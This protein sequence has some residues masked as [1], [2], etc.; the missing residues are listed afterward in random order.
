MNRHFH[1]LVPFEPSNFV[2][3][4][5]VTSLCEM[6]GFTL[7]EA[8]DAVLLSRPIYQAFKGDFGTKAK[9]A[10]ILKKLDFSPGSARLMKGRVECEFVSF[11]DRDQFGVD[12][13]GQ[14]ESAIVEAAKRGRRIRAILL[15]HPHNPLGR[16][17]TREALIAYMQLCEK[18]K[19]HLIM[20]E[21]YALSVYEVPDPQAT[22]FESIST[23]ETGRYIS[24]E[25]LHLIYGMS[26]DTAAGGIR[27]G[28]LYTL[29]AAL[30]K[31]MAAANV[32]HWSG[33]ISEKLA[34]ALL[35]DEEWMDGFLK[36]SRHALARRNVLTR[37]LLDE[38]GIEYYRGANA[39]FFLWVDLRPFLPNSILTEGEEDWTREE[40]LTDMLLD[41]KL[42]ITTG[43]TLSAEEPGW[44]RIIFAQDE[45]IIREGFRRSVFTRRS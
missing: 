10:L 18:H 36:R 42:F 38:A 22:E 27:L 7:F 34:T 3:A 23:F 9:Y 17:Y 11:G 40:A 20:D 5:G 33:N 26:K 35:E 37:K 25:Y 41:N 29:N 15:C 2:I 31:A 4:N 1:P 30:Q 19:I 45:S 21:I 6:L 14:Y 12:G 43:Q 39:G 13:V 44:Y 32:F 8:G 24:P 28:C 16:C